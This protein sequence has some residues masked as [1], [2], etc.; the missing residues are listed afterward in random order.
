MIRRSILSLCALLLLLFEFQAARS[1]NSEYYQQ[2]IVIELEE[3]LTAAQQKE[4]KEI[5]TSINLKGRHAVWQLPFSLYSASPKALEEKLN[6]WTALSGIKRIEPNY[7]YSILNGIPDDPEL[8]KQWP[9]DM[10]SGND[11]NIDLLSAWNLHPGEKAIIA[12]IIDTGIDFGHEDL[13]QNIWQNLAEDSD[14]DGRTIERI[15]GQWVLDPGDLDG[16]DADQNGYTDDLVG[17]DFVNNDNNPFDDNGH[18]THIAGIMGAKGNNGKGIAGVNWNMKLMALKAFDANG[19][20]ALSSILPAMKYARKMGV[21][22]SNSSYGSHAFSRIMYEEI[23]KHDRDKKLVVAA[24]GNE[25]SNNYTKPVY[26]ASYELDNIVSVAAGDNQ[27]ELSTFSNYGLYSVDLMAPGSQIYSSLPHGGYGYKDGTSMAA[28]FVTGTLALIWSFG[29]DLNHHQLKNI[30]LASVDQLPALYGKCVSSGKLNVHRALQFSSRICT[31]WYNSSSSF[32]VKG[33][34]EEGEYIWAATNQGLIRLKK[35][36]CEVKTFNKKN[37]D[38]PEDKIKAVGVDQQGVVWVATDKNGVLSYDGNSWTTYTKKSGLPDDKVRSILVDKDNRVWLGSEKKGI[39][40]YENGSWTYFNKKTGLPDDKIKS[41]GKDPDGNI[42]VSTQKGI[43]HY[44]QEEWTIFNKK[45]SGL[46]HDKLVGVAVAPDQTI[47]AATDRGLASF[48]GSSWTQYAKSNSGLPNDKI[49]SIGVDGD[50]EVWIG[51][52]RGLVEY[53]GNAWTVFKKSNSHLPDDHPHAMIV[54]DKGNTWVGTHKGIHVFGAKVLASFS[55]DPSICV[56]QTYTFSNATMNGTSFEWRLDGDLLS[57]DRDLTY[58]FDRAGTYLLTL[59]ASNRVSFNVFSRTIEVKEPLEIDLGPDRSLCAN[60]F[61][62]DACTEDLV[63]RW[64][65]SNG[66]TLGREK[67]FTVRESGTYTLIAENGCDQVANASVQLDLN[68]DCVWPGDANA[69]GRVNSMDFLTMGLLEGFQGNMRND[70]STQWEEKLADNWVMSFPDDH[71]LAADVNFKHADAN[72]DGLIEL[73]TDGQIVLQNAYMP[74][75]ESH[76]SSP[77][78]AI[79][80]LQHESTTILSEDT[81]LIEY[82]LKLDQNGGPVLDL[83]GLSFALDYNLPLAQEPGL[84]LQNGWMG[85]AETL[86]IHDWN[87]F[88]NC[89]EGGQRQLDIG[90]SRIDGQGATG[91]GKIGT[92]GIIVV[93]DDLA[94]ENDI[95][96]YVSLQITPRNPLILN[97]I[98]EFI[99]LNTTLSQVTSVVPLRLEKEENEGITEESFRSPEF[100]ALTDFLPYPNPFNEELTV[101]FSLEED[102]EVLIQLRNLQG[103][104]MKE[105][106]E[107]YVAGTHKSLLQFEDLPPGLYFLYLETENQRGVKRVWISE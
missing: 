11:G 40:V 33:L 85:N 3:E 62:L 8:E 70:R 22:I 68:G 47:W 56:D 38:L 74:A 20:G 36:D 6:Q 29:P 103:V 83:Y 69:D 82:E 32:D 52:D 4:I 28:P 100:P 57:T 58:H 84:N 88:Q 5:F 45:N 24:A 42:W 37:S 23:E 86:I 44:K 39:G 12:G 34:A 80:S 59:I 97:S 72:G 30:L 92:L 50:G 105:W 75:E 78:G 63:Y 96:G 17:W 81:A 89:L 49:L 77:N 91:S 10:I 46:P 25:A 71:S 101:S 73:S 21:D 104:L 1:Q 26:P 107:A 51:T 99:P 16:I 19:D 27:G 9:A 98:G 15:N 106:T 60:A 55:G 14:G 35:D 2:A 76:N 48:N 102:E 7:A 54:D 79:L 93:V 87:N 13:H 64:V 31:D 67:T 53:N 90:L 61:V 65:N 94:G 41:L 43:G 66:E 95:L 18:G